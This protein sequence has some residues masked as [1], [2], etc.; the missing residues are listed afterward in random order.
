MR[1]SPGCTRRKRRRIATITSGRPFDNLADLTRTQRNLAGV[2]ATRNAWK[3]LLGD[4]CHVWDW[5]GYRPGSGRPILGRTANFRFRAMSRRRRG[6]KTTAVVGSRA[7]HPRLAGD[8]AAR[9]DG[10]RPMLA[11]RRRP[12]LASAGSTRSRLTL[13][14]SGH[15]RVDAWPA[16]VAA[17]IS[18]AI[19]ARAQLR[20]G[21][22]A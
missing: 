3:D 10:E 5:Q 20:L 17:L 15:P 11:C 13:T 1:T 4:R 7:V 14:I 19:V 9:G 6:L 8:S 2:I 22:L 21:R 16:C 18:T 12:K